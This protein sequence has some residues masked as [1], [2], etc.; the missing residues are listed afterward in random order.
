M[1][2]AVWYNVQHSTPRCV[3]KNLQPMRT[4]RFPRILALLTAGASVGLAACG[5]SGC[6]LSHRSGAQSTPK[7]AAP[8]PV[9]MLPLDLTKFQPNEAG[10][11]PILEYHNLMNSS[12]TTG[13]E[14]PI[15]SF[16]KD[17]DWLYAHK[18]RPISLSD[19]VKGRID[20]PAGMS[21]VILTFDDALGGQFRYLA[22]G[23]IDPNCGVGVLNALH[24]K[25]ADWPLRATFFVLTD[26]DPKMPPPFYQSTSAERKMRYLV[27][28]GFEIG[29]HTVHHRQGMRHWTAPQ[30]E[31]EFA[32]AVAGI[33]K[34]LPGYNV[35]T[36]ALPYG[37]YPK[38]RKLC[39]KGESGGVSYFNICAM[40]AGA[41]PAP[42]PMAKD[43]N[44]YRL[45]RIIPGNERFALRYWLDDLEAH[46]ELKFVSDGDPNTYTVNVD[47]LGDMNAQRIRNHHYFLRVYNG[48]EIVTPNKA[49]K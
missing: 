41:N 30:V 14:Y 2:C 7:K 12:R 38:D 21:P 43:F 6:R 4:L 28:E 18:Y 1:P 25:H 33:H 42:S 40:L 29:N 23:E 34:Y 20:C 35:E 31:A 16:R 47:S 46:K 8:A 9:K 45:P 36:L 48:K 39:I 15:A 5:V 11:V 10:M 44:P 22:N 32:G 27:S 3:R 17:M 49:A 19:Y 26:E 24:A 13:Y 37:V